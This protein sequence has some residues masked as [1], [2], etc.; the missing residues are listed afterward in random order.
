MSPVL[1]CDAGGHAF[2]ANDPNKRKYTEELTYAAGGPQT[3]VVDVCG[4]HALKVS[5]TLQLTAEPAEAGG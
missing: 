4:E 5:S 1:W 3:L 2:P